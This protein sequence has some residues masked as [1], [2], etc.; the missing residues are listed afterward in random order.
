M[1]QEVIFSFR[2]WKMALL[3]NPQWVAHLHS[4][5][6]L[7]R[8]W[9]GSTYGGFFV[10]PDYLRAQSIVYSVGIGKDISFD[11]KIIQNHGCKVFA[12][13]PTPKSIQYLAELNLPSE[14]IFHPWGLAVQSGPQT[15][16][17]PKDDRGVSG[18]REMNHAVDAQK[19]IEVDMKSLP[20]LMNLMGHSHIDLLKIDIEGSEYEVIKDVLNRSITIN[21]LLIEFHDRFFNTDEPRSLATIQQLQEAGYRIFATSRNKEEISLIHERMLTS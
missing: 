17:L 9:Y 3:Q 10:C 8:R 13:D 16:Y 4:N 7:P 6:K 20:D 19:S 1:R 14:F 21:Q 2:S 5:I 15:F 12:F 18:S 11:R